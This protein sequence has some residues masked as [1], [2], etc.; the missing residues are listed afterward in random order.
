MLCHLARSSASLACLSAPL[1]S[2][3][4][5]D[6]SDSCKHTITFALHIKLG[7]WY[8]V[9]FLKV[10]PRVN[11][12]LDLVRERVRNGPQ[13]EQICLKPDQGV[14]IH[15]QPLS[16]CNSALRTKHVPNY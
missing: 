1:Q 4:Y 8:S 7:R 12:D 14:V 15:T 3:R 16:S 13:Q 2:Q 9:M 11:K 10:K 6:V 5:Q